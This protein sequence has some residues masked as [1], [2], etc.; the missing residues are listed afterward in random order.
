MT[1]VSVSA[2]PAESTGTIR[3]VTA[4][5]F[6]LKANHLSGRIRQI[7]CFLNARRVTSTG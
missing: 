1:M 5:I 3:P 2:S 7:T 6:F 4:V